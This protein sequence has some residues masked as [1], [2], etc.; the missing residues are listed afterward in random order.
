[1]SETASPWYEA[2]FDREYLDI[3]AHRDAADAARALAFLERE[4]VVRPG[5]R[6][7]DLCCGNGRHSLPLCRA[8]HLVTGFDLSQALLFDFRA[9][10]G[11]AISLVRGDMRALAFRDQAFGAVLSLFTSFG[12]FEDDDENWGVLREIVRVLVPGGTF[13]LDFLNASRVRAGLRPHSERTLASGLRVV[14]DRLIDPERRRVI[15]RVALERNGRTI[16]RWE[17]SV[18][19]FTRDELDS[20]ATQAGLSGLRAF[21]D[22]DSSPALE[23]SP[24]L[25]LIGR[26]AVAR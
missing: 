3:Y 21:G 25:I 17:E 18:R 23:T 19:L 1:M 22:F 7:L 13:C 4:K 5:H 26:A 20:A 15:K 9:R 16:R 24:R 8:G 11:C 2:A 6:V 12:Y 10:A 14:E